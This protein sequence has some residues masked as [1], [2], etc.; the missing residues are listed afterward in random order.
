MCPLFNKCFATK[1]SKQY[2]KRHGS[3]FNILDLIVK[4]LR[5]FKNVV[6]LTVLYHFA[7]LA[8]LPNQ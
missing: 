1:L 5:M 6:L 4:Y 8:Y 3:T 7:A 2:Y